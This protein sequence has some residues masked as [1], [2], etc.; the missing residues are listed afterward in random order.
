MA[1]HQQD[2]R[3]RAAALVD[4]TFRRNYQDS[5]REHLRQEQRQLAWHKDMLGSHARNREIAEA[6]Y[7]ERMKRIERGY[8][9]AAEA[10]HKRHN[11]FAG[12]MERLTRAGRDRQEATRQALE[13]RR[14][15]LER[16]ETAQFN[17][18]RERQFKAEQQER[19]DIAQHMRFFRAE[20]LDERRVQRTH[21]EV[22]RDY[23]I[24]QRVNQMRQVQEQRLRVM[25][26]ELERQHTRGLSR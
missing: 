20:H 6:R 19:I 1:E 23:L 24:D 17:A 2:M 3:A 25:V 26:Q 13:D 22:S 5:F 8:E 16:R 12:R 21:F 14:L 15:T 7:V 4:G 18:L 10:V 9:R 11:S